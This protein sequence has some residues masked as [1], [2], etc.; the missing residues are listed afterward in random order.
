MFL[1]A[2]RPCQLAA[3]DLPCLYQVR[4]LKASWHA[5]GSWPLLGCDET[6]TAVNVVRSRHSSNKLLRPKG[7]TTFVVPQTPLDADLAA[8]K[9]I[10]PD[11]EPED[12]AARYEQRGISV[13]PKPVGR[14]FEDW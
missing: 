4:T 3:D 2:P 6:T 1:R 10:R 14:G 11:P 5:D 7:Q 13:G 8:G 9:V 12:V